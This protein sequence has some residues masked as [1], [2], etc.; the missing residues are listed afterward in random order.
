MSIPPP[1]IIL[2]CECEAANIA[3]TEA[4]ENIHCLNIS[5]NLKTRIVEA[6]EI[7]FRESIS[8]NFFQHFPNEPRSITIEVSAEVGP[9][10][11]SFN[12]KFNFTCNQCLS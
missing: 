6:I 8:K 3:F 1:R 12:E 5:S 11:L 9:V 7:V 2:G 4:C 10:K